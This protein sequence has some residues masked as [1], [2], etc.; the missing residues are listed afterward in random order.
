[1]MV[2]MVGSDEKTRFTL[3]GGIS[4]IQIRIQIFISMLG[5]LLTDEHLYFYIKPYTPKPRETIT[6]LCLPTCT[7]K[8]YHD[9]WYTSNCTSNDKNK[10]Y[11]QTCTKKK[12]QNKI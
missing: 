4:K 1:M 9:N 5:S 8:L 3:M 6:I 7:L 12:N 11:A 2:I 10:H